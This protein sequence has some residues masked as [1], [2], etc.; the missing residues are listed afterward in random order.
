M[1]DGFCI[2]FRTDMVSQIDVAR[3]STSRSKFIRAILENNKP[4]SGQKIG[5]QGLNVVSESTPPTPMKESMVR[6]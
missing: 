1:S 4:H 6:S 3:K 2:Y 5:V